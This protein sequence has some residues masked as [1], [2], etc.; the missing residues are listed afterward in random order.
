[1]DRTTKLVATLSLIKAKDLK[2]YDLQ[3]DLCVCNK[4][5]S[6]YIWKV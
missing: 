3:R 1:M 5:L 2:L 4:S 6:K